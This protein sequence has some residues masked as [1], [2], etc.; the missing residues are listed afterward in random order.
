MTKDKILL[1]SRTV[2][3]LMWLVLLES[4][5]EIDVLGPKSWDKAVHDCKTAGK[6]LY[7]SYREEPLK[8]ILTASSGKHWVGA[9]T[10]YSPWRWAEDDTT[11]FTYMGYRNITYED[12]PKIALNYDNEAVLCHTKCE[13]TYI[14]MQ[15]L[16]TISKSSR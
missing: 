4:E 6:E 1:F 11:V 12:T 9:K 14:G 13:T 10:M 3:I 7:S 16:H 8:E 15:Y 5:A 2:S